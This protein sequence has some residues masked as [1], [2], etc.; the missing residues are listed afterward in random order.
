M[1]CIS[2]SIVV[3]AIIYILIRHFIF[4]SDTELGYGDNNYLLNTD[5]QNRLLIDVKRVEYVKSVI[6][7]LQQVKY[8]NERHAYLD[9]CSIC[10]AKYDESDTLI[11]LYC[12][13]RHYFH[14][15]CIISWF[16][17]KAKAQCHICQRAV[18]SEKSP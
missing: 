4:P 13:K 16:N 18:V 7:K 1:D 2:I 6:E 14:K 10:L 17:E 12:D 15:D 9:K 5:P 3:M 11:E 8:S